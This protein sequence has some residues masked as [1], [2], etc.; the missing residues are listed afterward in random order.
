MPRDR[1]LC[2]IDRLLCWRGRDSFGDR[3]EAIAAEEAHEARFDLAD[4]SGAGKDECGIKLDEAGTSAD[5]CIG[6]L[7]TRDPT[8]A[9]QGQAPLC[10][11]IHLGEKRGRRN[12]Q[13]AAAEPARLLRVRADETGRPLDCRVRDDQT[14]DAGFERDMGDV[15]ALF[16]GQIGSNLDQQW[17]PCLACAK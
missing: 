6:I 16:G 1:S 14:V 2:A 13:R 17:D 11:P 3:A 7:G 4:E 10:Q 12:E 5:L 15:L 8:G 9:D